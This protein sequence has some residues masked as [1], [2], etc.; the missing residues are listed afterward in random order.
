MMSERISQ[1][2]QSLERARSAVAEGATLDLD[3][4]CA[5]VEAAMV[6]AVKAPVGERGALTA[7]LTDLLATLERL[8][9]D[10]TRQHRGE[11]QRR[12]AA[13]Y[14]ASSGRVDGKK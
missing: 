6:D 14:G 7:A 12:A 11:A 4:L 2:S 8:S 13:A 10:L 1:I 3:G 5:T 9:A